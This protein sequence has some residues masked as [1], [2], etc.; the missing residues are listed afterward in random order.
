[1]LECAD[2]RVWPLA[3]LLAAC[4][5]SPYVDFDAG[6]DVHFI[7]VVEGKPKQVETVCTVGAVSRRPPK[8]TI[9]RAAEVAVLR[10]SE[11]DHRISIWE[12]R[13]RSGARR[14]VDVTR[15]LW[16][17]MTVRPGDNES[18][19]DVHRTPPRDRAWQPL[20]AVPR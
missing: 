11:G 4:S 7:L 16:L 8:R 5:S 14:S 1:M 18:P 19:L 10:V 9:K 17:V 6:H 20:V 12:Q 3:L 13:N 2:M 15:D